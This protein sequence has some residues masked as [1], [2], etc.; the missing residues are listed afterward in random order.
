MSAEKEEK[1]EVF[2]PFRLEGVFKETSNIFKSNECKGAKDANTIIVLDTNTLLLPYN[3]KGQS[4]QNL[5]EVYELFSKQNRLFIPSRVAREF[6]SN[7]DY[8]LAEIVQSIEAA[9]SR[10]VVGD[11]YHSPLLDALELKS[12]LTD[13]HKKMKIAKKDYFSAIDSIVDTV[14][15][16]NGNDPITIAY[17]RIFNSTNIVDPSES[18]DSL[19]KEWEYRK[20]NKIP[21]GYK[22]S[23]KDDTGI[24]DFIIWSTILDI[25]R[26]ENKDMIFITSEEK[27]DWF[28][29]V[30]NK[31][32]YARPELIAEYKTASSG[33]SLRISNL[34]DILKEM[35]S[36]DAVV[37]QFAQ[38]ES[39]MAASLYREDLKI[40]S[41]SYSGARTRMKRSISATGWITE[42][43]HLDGRGNI[44]DLE[45][46]EGSIFLRATPE[47]SKKCFWIG[48]D[49][50]AISYGKVT[51]D[52]T[53]EDYDTSNLHEVSQPIPIVI[54]DTFFAR[55]GN[56]YIIA[57]FVRHIRV[58]NNSHLIDLSYKP[59]KLEEYE[60]DG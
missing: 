6:I 18:D 36:P 16:W 12:H 59:I 31:P 27:P 41:Q 5:I 8:K 19:K 49:N 53:K 56:V 29:S 24:G 51:Q 7:R 2:S 38:A 32:V 39:S 4:L 50:S 48:T 1:K 35:D 58:G 42:R 23:N 47:F 9:K 33:R 57:N 45:T 60:I 40:Q 28:I 20:I 54:G 55:E 46:P 26:K 10:I 15:K 13:L 14:T 25:A 3:V 30:N 17:N 37:K 21:P 11:Q 34:P 44:I 43:F 52:S 22:D